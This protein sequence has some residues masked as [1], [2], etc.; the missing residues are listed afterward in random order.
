MGKKLATAFFWAVASCMTLWL[1]SLAQPAKASFE[2]FW[3]F[4]FMLLAGGGAYHFLVELLQ[5]PTD[6]G[7]LKEWSGLYRAMLW[8]MLPIL[9][10]PLAILAAKQWFSPAVA[11]LA[12]YVYLLIAFGLSFSQ[13]MEVERQFTQLRSNKARQPTISAT[14]GHGT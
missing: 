3:L 4:S 11:F 6:A 12:G 5:L 7:V 8:F 9:S 13:A 2:S 10:V 14:G 1:F